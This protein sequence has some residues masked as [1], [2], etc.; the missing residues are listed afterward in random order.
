MNSQIARNLLILSALSIAH[1]QS[2]GSFTQTV[3]TNGRPILK[4]SNRS[5]DI[6]INGGSGDMLE[7]KGTLLKHP[8]RSIPASLKD[9]IA[10]LQENPPIIVRD[11]RIT[12]QPV[13]RDLAKYI[14]INYDL[15]VPTGTDLE[16][17]TGSGDIQVSRLQPK[18]DLSTGSGDIRIEDLKEGGNISTGSGDVTGSSTMGKLLISTGSGDLSFTECGG[19]YIL[20]TGSGSI[21]LDFANDGKVD[22]STGS[23][24][25]RFSHLIGIAR[26]HTGSGDISVSGYP[27][28]DW[29]LQSSS[30]DV[31]ID[32]ANDAGANL[33]AKSTS[34][35]I[36]INL[37]LQI[38]ESK[39]HVLKAVINQG[40]P[41]LRVRTTSGDIEVY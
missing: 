15:V 27:T 32:L 38:V 25:L 36:D 5:G 2:I 9:D 41:E 12:V 19:E 20:S 40:G 34:G 33:D 26:A 1:S 7:I 17:A 8:M 37:Q 39:K 24:D 11:N 35:D 21:E 3:N 16:A 29:S 23:G 28:G 13:D 6:S 14:H 18:V 30:G 10:K 22:A 31:D 4:I